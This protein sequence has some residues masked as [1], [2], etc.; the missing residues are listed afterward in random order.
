MTGRLDSVERLAGLLQGGNVALHG[1]PGYGKSRLADLVEVRLQSMERQVARLDMSTLTSGC[2]FLSELASHLGMTVTEANEGRSLHEAWRSVRAELT[3]REALWTLILDQFD[4]VGRWPDA[5]Q[6]LPI[7]RELIHRPRILHCNAMIVSRRSLESIEV[8]VVG[9]S[10]LASV[11]FVEYLGLVEFEDLTADWEQAG[12]CS[13]E[14]LRAC[15]EWSGGHPVLVNYWLGARP[16]KH[17]GPAVDNQVAHVMGRLVGYLD[18]LELL[19]PAAQLILGPVVE[20]LFRERLRLE[21]MGIVGTGEGGRPALAEHEVFCDLVRLNTRDMNPWGVLGAAEVRA[22]SIVE[23]VFSSALGSDWD[24]EVKAKD[25]MVRQTF[26]RAAVLMQEDQRK[27]GRSVHWLAYTYPHDLWVIISR[28][29][30]LFAP[31]F[32]GGDK[33]YWQTRFAALAK[34]RTP[35][36]HNRSIVLSSDERVQGRIYSKEIVSRVDDYLTSNSVKTLEV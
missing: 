18:E 21:S 12:E 36:A 32:T 27:F 6:F 7:M 25:G 20:D 1:G 4:A 5:A 11:C 3:H 8:G 19:A 2:A 10:T 24:D 33:K 26:D 30:D 9:I 29:W 13:H 15:L 34:Y 22:R 17:G 35:V 14:D 31:V 16:D 28:H 23:F